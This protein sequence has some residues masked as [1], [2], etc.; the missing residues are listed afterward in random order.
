MKTTSF[1]SDRIALKETP[2]ELEII[3]SGKVPQNQLVLLSAWGIAWTIAGIYVFTQV[4]LQQDQNTLLFMI[5]WLGFWAYFEFKVVSAWLWRKY[6]RE[7]LRMK[8]DSTE[9]RFEVA[10][11]GKGDAL[12]TADIRNVT[13]LEAQKGLFIKNHYSSFWVVGGETIGFYHQGKLYMMGRQIPEK[14]AALLIQKIEH[15]LRKWAA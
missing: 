2:D 7:V 5:V 9:L 8:A 6:G 11:G 15:R 14:D 12:K 1:E 13:S 3:I 4:F 10:Y